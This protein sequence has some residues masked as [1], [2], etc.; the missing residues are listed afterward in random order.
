[1]ANYTDKR[2]CAVCCRL[3]PDSELRRVNMSF[4]LCRRCD[5]RRD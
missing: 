5:E 1:M 2:A 3:Y 4:Y